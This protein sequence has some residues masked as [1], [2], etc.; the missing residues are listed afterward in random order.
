MKKVILFLILSIGVTYGQTLQGS[1]I[2][3]TYK[4]LLRFNNSNNGIDATLRIIY[5]GKGTAT[6]LSM[7]TTAMTISVIT[8]FSEGISIPSTKYIYLAG[9]ASTNGSWRMGATLSGSLLI[10]KRVAGSWVTASTLTY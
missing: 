2:S 1:G 9:D 10:E 6:P 4:D 5:D 8:T 7:S 3:N